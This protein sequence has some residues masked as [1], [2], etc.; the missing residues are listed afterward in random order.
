MHE[1]CDKNYLQDLKSVI[2]KS[3]ITVIYYFIVCSTVVPCMKVGNFQKKKKNPVHGVGGK[4]LEIKI[5]EFYKS[6]H[7]ILIVYTSRSLGLDR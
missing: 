1:Y 7:L 3:V 6:I 5:L 4:C 2:L